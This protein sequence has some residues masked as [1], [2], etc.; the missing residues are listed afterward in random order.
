MADDAYD[1]I[2]R[3]MA[4]DV[5][6]LLTALNSEVPADDR[7]ACDE[8]AIRL[9]EQACDCAAESERIRLGHPPKGVE[10]VKRL[11]REVPR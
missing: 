2:H 10:L 9:I 3:Q 4:T 5:W 8:A 6:R 11:M 1:G 7:A